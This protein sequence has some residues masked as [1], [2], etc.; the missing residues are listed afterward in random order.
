MPTPSAR[1]STCASAVAEAIHERTA[2]R[3]F[4]LQE[5]YIRQQDLRYHQK[6]AGGAVRNAAY[7]ARREE[8]LLNHPEARDVNLGDSL[9]R[10]LAQLVR[11]GDYLLLA[12]RAP[13]RSLPGW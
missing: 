12:R 9:N 7:H 6:R 13:G 2:A 1:G 10:N 3:L 8:Q 4:L 11:L 5:G